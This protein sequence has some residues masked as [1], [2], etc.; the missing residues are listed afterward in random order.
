MAITNLD[1]MVTTKEEDMVTMM[2]IDIIGKE[3]GLVHIFN[4]SLIVQ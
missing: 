4:I 1:T 2:A 3:R